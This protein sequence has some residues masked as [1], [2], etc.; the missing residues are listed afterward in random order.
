MQAPVNHAD[1]GV[2]VDPQSTVTPKLTIHV[3]DVREED[4][5]LITI[6]IVE[7]TIQDNITFSVHG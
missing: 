3:S 6:I 2:E 4:I 1:K 5:A 7:Y